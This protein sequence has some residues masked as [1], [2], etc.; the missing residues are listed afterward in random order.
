MD[1]VALAKRTDKTIGMED[2][3]G[4]YDFKKTFSIRNANKKGAKDDVFICDLIFY[5]E[6]KLINQALNRILLQNKTLAAR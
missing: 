4:D 3:Y 2:K 5:S 6:K 1:H